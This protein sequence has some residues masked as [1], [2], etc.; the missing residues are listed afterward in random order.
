[1]PASKIFLGNQEF[2]S[3][4]A[5]TSHTAR[6]NEAGGAPNDNGYSI[7]LSYLTIYEIKG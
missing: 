2:A 1:M 3:E 7:T 4:S 5:N 6:I